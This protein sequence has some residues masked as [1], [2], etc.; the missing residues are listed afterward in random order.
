[1]TAL[2]AVR[3]I[4]HDVVRLE[5]RHGGGG[6]PTDGW[7]DKSAAFGP[8]QAVGR[9]KQFCQPVAFPAGASNQ[10]AKHFNTLTA[11]GKLT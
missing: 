4:L 3:T 5:W 9:T 10:H 7:Q 2:S 1:M 6:R 11:I 8:A